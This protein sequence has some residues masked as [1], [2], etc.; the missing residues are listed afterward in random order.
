MS[1]LRRISAGAGVNLVNLLF[2][3]VV[4]VLTPPILVH[5]WGLNQYGVWVM[6]TALPTY[7][8]LTDFGFATAATNDIAMHVARGARDE[9]RRVLQ[10]VWAL[11]LLTNAAVI[12][13][14]SVI[15]VGLATITS[16]PDSPLVRYNGT[17]LLLTLYALA[18]M[19]S[20][21]VLGV[22][23]A[24]GLY[25]KGSFINDTLQFLEGLAGLA[26]AFLGGDFAITAA[27]LLI[28][29]MV[30]LAIMAELLRHD[31]PD[32][33]LGLGLAN[34]E[35]LRRLLKPAMAS[36]V[37]PTSLALNMQGVALIVGALISPAAAATLAT[38]RTVSRTAVQFIS[39]IN[40]ATIPEMSAAAA[41]GET[42][43]LARIR[44]INAVLLLG[45]AAP[46]ALGF[47][48][49]GPWVVQLWTGGAI[50]PSHTVV[51]FLAAAMF[52]HCIWY[53]G[54]NLLSATNAHGRMTF[55]LLGSSVL[56]IGLA[57][58]LTQVWGLAGACVA[59]MVGE[60][61]C[62]LWF[63]H[64]QRTIRNESASRPEGHASA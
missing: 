49:L 3:T 19:T 42:G 24:C 18:T 13:L 28:S 33:P 25:A 6:L 8:I 38:A 22:F 54:T 58:A 17:I 39:A 34:K 59:V 37:I 43:T 57:I 48:A 30:S 20:R 51:G 21:T 41:R 46:A 4:T 44:R 29:R 64:V 47:A 35:T 40:R 31:L 23:R 60:L 56:A 12:A 2:V 50:R 16:D 1:S 7:L 9:A 61:A 27:T 14:L 11:N 55:G 32:M 5:T 62:V 36:M 10:S 15:L 63:L 53:F 45:V 52:L 26:A